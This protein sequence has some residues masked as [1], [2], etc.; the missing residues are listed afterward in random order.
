M[1][2]DRGASLAAP[3]AADVDEYI[4]LALLA[5]RIQKRLVAILEYLVL[6][7]PRNVNRPRAVGRP[8]VPLV[9]HALVSQHVAFVVGSRWQCVACG[10]SPGALSA[11]AALH[12]LATP[13]SL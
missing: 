2:A 9:G 3:A 5:Q 13:L 4:R 1:L 7:F 8:R 10:E 11:H 12:W 6:Y